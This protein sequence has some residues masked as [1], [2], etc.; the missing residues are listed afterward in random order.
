VN[1]PF[2]DFISYEDIFIHEKRNFIQSVAHATDFTSDNFTGIELDLDSIE[3]ILSSASTPCGINSLHARQYINFAAM[4]SKVAYLHIC[5]GAT[6][7]DNGETNI[8]TGKLISYLVSD[9]IKA[10]LRK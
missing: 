9:F 7:L 10:N 2:I 6:K 1:N 8:S 4:A 5:E 3:N